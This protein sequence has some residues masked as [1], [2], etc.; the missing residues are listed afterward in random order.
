MPEAAAD[1]RPNRGPLG[2]GHASLRLERTKKNLSGSGTR[3]PASGSLLLRCA[4]FS[5]LQKSDAKRK[6]LPLGLVGDVVFHE[7]GLER[8][9]TKLWQEKNKTRCISESKTIVML[10]PT[11][12]TLSP[13]FL[14][15]G[16]L[17]RGS[18]PSPPPTS[19][20]PPLCLG[21]SSSLPLARFSA[22][23][24]NRR[25]VPSSSRS[26]LRLPWLPPAG[27]GLCSF[28]PCRGSGRQVLMLRGSG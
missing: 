20:A 22:A 3:S 9:F 10:T 17:Q 26:A 28:E 6:I 7:A 13:L 24:S 25:C 12:N 27:A 4:S 23:L 14:A 19:H 16:R 15:S 2:G 11:L 5:C 8:P 21:R 18:N 1:A